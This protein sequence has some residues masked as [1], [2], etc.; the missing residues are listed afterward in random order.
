MYDEEIEN[1]QKR[2][3]RLVKLIKPSKFITILLTIGLLGPIG[4]IVLMSYEGTGINAWILVLAIFCFVLIVLNW[5]IYFWSL[6]EFKKNN[7][8]ILTAKNIEESKYFLS[9]AWF[10]LATGITK[11]SGVDFAHVF[12]FY[13]YYNRSTFT[14]NEINHALTILIKNQYLELTSD[15]KI[16][17]LAKTKRIFRWLGPSSVEKTFNVLNNQED[18]SVE[19]VIEY[20][21]L[22]NY[23]QLI[24]NYGIYFDKL[25]K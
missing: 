19:Q 10:L 6:R 21:T 20:I 8:L 13:D 7:N 15:L 2:I 1:A 24:R 9:D 12:Y 17:S 22:Q 11:K 25:N 5:R 23:D 16:K 3:D 4:N 14:R 18:L